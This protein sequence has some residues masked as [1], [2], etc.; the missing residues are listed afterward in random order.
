MAI[1]AAGLTLQIGQLCESRPQT[2]VVGV[3]APG[4]DG[5][6]SIQVDGRVF[7]V[8]WC[9]SPLAVSEQLVDAENTDGLVIVTPLNDSDLGLDVLARFERRRL[10]H[11]EQWEMVRLAYGVTALDARLPMQSWMAQALLA[12][13]PAEF[14]SAT[15]VL[16]ATTAWSHVFDHAL[17]LQDGAPD[18][19]ALLRWSLEPSAAERFAALPDALA[20]AA[21]AR[22]TDA[23]GKVGELLGNALAAGEASSL[24]PI[25]LVCEVLFAADVEPAEVRAQAIARLEPMLG[26]HTIDAARGQPWADAARR[27]LIALPQAERGTWL[28]RAER[29]LARLRAEALGVYSTVLPSGFV[30]RLDEFST[31]ASTALQRAARLAQAEQA[32]RRVLAHE[33]CDTEPDRVHG[34]EM[35]MRLVRRLAVT[36]GRPPTRF[37]ELMQQ[38]RADGAFEDWARRYLLGGDPHAGV[39]TL[40]S[41]TY[42]ALRGRRETANRVFAEAACAW[43][44]SPDQSVVP[45]ER[46]LPQIVG[47]AARQVPVL[48]LVLDGMDA[49]VFEELSD[50][51]YDRGWRRQ[52]T[53]APDTL[54]AV[55]PSVTAASRTAL[56]T[57]EV[58][59]GQAVLEKQGFA[60]H[61]DLLAVSRPRRGPV[62]FHKS[63]L[64]EGAAQG[65]A[66]AVRDAVADEQQ[67]VVGVVLNAVDDHL[68]KAEQLRL[69]WRVDSV[70]LLGAVLDAARLSGRAVIVTSDHGHVLEADGERLEGDTEGRWRRPPPDPGELEVPVSGTRVRAATGFET[71]V[72]PWSERVRYGYRKNGYHGGATLQEAVVLVGVF[73]PPGESVE[74]WDPELRTVPDWWQAEQAREAVESPPVAPSD[75]RQLGLLEMKAAE[76]ARWQPLL[77]SDV[78]A[79]QRGLAG[80]VVPDD[81]RVLAA[82]N[83]LAVAHGRL[84]LTAFAERVDV[85]TRRVRGFVAG[86]QR[87]LNA[88]GYSVLSL[89]DDME[90]VELDM[91]L[92]NTQFGLR[93]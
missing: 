10:M 77:E 71:I 26:D 61:P 23:A 75:E 65:L 46:F 28:E 50:D 87:L 30:R 55:L 59:S 17:G 68:D 42:G 9:P 16:D 88:D 58:T 41:R 78:F 82:L 90:R 3:H 31:A 43:H 18:A 67:R 40:Y 60:A 72:V 85:S 35:A 79:A 27:V 25:G 38:H 7:R 11:L 6:D 4:W 53:G 20:V 73:L 86:L 45:I 62:L 83:V 69:T 32:F 12:A 24:L 66:N 93:R 47:P 21:C 44:A 84:P 57:G 76:D 49:G 54:L 33:A 34:L 74:A 39:A 36:S 51:L 2:R 15:G 64:T 56:L 14:T 29:L 19:D 63:E 80:R 52:R 37:V 92:L 13:R 8:A 91:D 1:S 81:A 5:G 48:V 89:D 22:F 70:P